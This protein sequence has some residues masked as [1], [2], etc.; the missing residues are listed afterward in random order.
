M[1]FGVEHLSHQHHFFLYHETWSDKWCCV[2]REQYHW[3]RGQTIPE[4]ERKKV[5]KK[6]TVDESERERE[7]M[8]MTKDA[9]LN[10]ELA[11][12]TFPNR[13]NDECAEKQRAMLWF[14]VVYR[15][16]GRLM[17]INV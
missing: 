1:I 10:D 13:N 4:R 12:E 6:L 8:L 11:R 15:I 5:N 14:T 3:T 16:E 9:A 17:R 7:T 2:R